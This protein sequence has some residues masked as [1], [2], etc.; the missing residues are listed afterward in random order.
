MSARRSGLPW[1]LTQEASKA[2]DVLG[3]LLSHLQLSLGKVGLLQL[4]G[5]LALLDLDLGLLTGAQ[6]AIPLC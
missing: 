2:F 3:E 4:S 1:A 5:L 6:E